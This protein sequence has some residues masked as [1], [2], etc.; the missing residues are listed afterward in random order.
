MQAE[1]I[2]EHH[3][4]T[5]PV[6]LDLCH[7]FGREN[8]SAISNLV[9]TLFRRQP[10]FETDIPQLVTFLEEVCVLINM[11]INSSY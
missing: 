4:F 1:L 5:L 11:F 6:I 10:R 7:L 2:Y 9:E 8:N 3:V